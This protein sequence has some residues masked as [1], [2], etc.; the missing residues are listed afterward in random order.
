MEWHCPDL[1][2]YPSPW[3]EASGSSAPSPGS[4]VSREVDTSLA[5]QQLCPHSPPRPT[6]GTGSHAQWIKV[7]PR[8]PL[9]G[10]PAYP[11]WQPTMP[12]ALGL[13]MP[14]TLPWAPRGVLG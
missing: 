8:W 6:P 7:V 11:S 5:S 12:W 9:E 10:C 14:S 13:T 3:E 4:W 2:R 1:D